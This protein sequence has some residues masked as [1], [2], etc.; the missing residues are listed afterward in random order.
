MKKREIKNYGRS[1]KD[2]LLTV[3]IESGIPYMTILVRYIQERLLYRL[4]QSEYCNNFFLKGGALLYAFNQ[5]KAR[6]TKDID[7]LG[8]HI[9]N[10]SDNKLLKLHWFECE[11]YKMLHRF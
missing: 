6:P 1:V 7:F 9:S 5:E 2:R 8:T 11:K 3:S 4:A 10:D